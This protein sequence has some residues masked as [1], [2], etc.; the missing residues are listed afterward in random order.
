MWKVIVSCLVSASI[1]RVSSESICDIVGQLQTKSEFSVLSPR[2]KHAKRKPSLQDCLGGQTGTVIWS[3]LSP[4]MGRRID[5][6]L[7][8]GPV[9]FCVEFKGGEC[10]LIDRL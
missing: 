5:G 6:V 7:L 9:V 4:R 8:I 3:S 1:N 10:R 2:R